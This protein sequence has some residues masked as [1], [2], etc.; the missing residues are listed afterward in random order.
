MHSATIFFPFITSLHCLGCPTEMH[1]LIRT[2][3]I[4]VHFTYADSALNILL[5]V[6]IMEVAA[7]INTQWFS[8]VY[9]TC[10]PNL[11][12]VLKHVICVCD[13]QSELSSFDKE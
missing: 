13:P 3:E 8:H 11:D 7:C 10:F 6:K 9:L 1:A 2:F 4:I 5:S 12:P